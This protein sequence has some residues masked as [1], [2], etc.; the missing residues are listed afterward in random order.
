MFKLLKNP[1]F[2]YTIFWSLY[3]CQ[4]VF[5]PSDSLISKTIALL[6][7]ILSL[8]YTYK[9][10]SSSVL[11]GYAKALFYVLILISVYGVF[12]YVTD[13]AVIIGKTY[14]TKL[15]M[16]FRNLYLSI[17]PIFTYLY[18]AK[19]NYLTVQFV[20]KMFLVVLT[21]V[22]VSYYWS[23]LTAIKM[24]Y[25]KTG[26][27]VEDV[28]NNAGYIVLTMIPM[29]L[30]FD[31]KKL[32]QYIGLLAFSA[33]VVLSMK[34]GA[35]LICGIISSLFVFRSLNHSSK[36]SKLFVLLL[37]IVLST[38]L[39]YFLID[40]MAENDYFMSRLES[41]KEGKMSGRD[42]VYTTL[43]NHFLNNRSLLKTIFGGGVWY[44]T[45]V[46]WTAAH[47]DWLEFLLDMGIIGVAIYVAYWF[48]FYKLSRNKR[49]P[50]LSRFCVLLIFMDLFMRTFFSMSL[51]SIT[52]MHS[53]MLGLSYYGL[54]N[55]STVL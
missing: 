33:L 43:W 5:Y 41:T 53:M 55:T 12:A 4:G 6:I 34:R 28:T 31:N 21:A 47:N 15:F 35:I 3:Y 48:S 44:T 52:F 45:K 51:D 27:E 24:T 30:V 23:H 17:L 36:N 2:W 29:L 25:L 38:F 20:R 14:N 54:I 49:L 40:Y 22:F 10:L 16:W 11:T 1:C 7:L 32:I 18:F 19:S 8:F 13:G 50:E 9:Y 42:D 46:T 26:N 37:I 39:Y